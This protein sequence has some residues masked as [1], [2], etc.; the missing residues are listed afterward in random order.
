MN[1]RMPLPTPERAKL[2]A[3]DFWL[4]A[5]SGAFDRYLKSE[6]IEGEIWVMSAVHRW[7]A[8]TVAYLT[9]ELTL[10]LRQLGSELIV[11][12]SGSVDLSDDSVPEPDVSVGEDG[13]GEGGLPRGALRL[14]IEVSDSTRKIDLGRKAALYARHGVPEYWVASREDG[15]VFQ[16]WQPTSER[17]ARRERVAFGEMINARSIDGLRMRA[18]LA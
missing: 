12:T 15:C 2:R 11:F 3:E 8:K 9:A 17:F 4:L 18:P 13:D 7:H 6:L 14:A 16:H 1:A 5:R 10:A